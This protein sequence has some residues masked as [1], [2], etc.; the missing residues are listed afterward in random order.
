MKN[1]RSVGQITHLARQLYPHNKGMLEE[2]YQDCMKTPYGYL[3]ID[4]SPGGAD[5]YR[6]RSKIFPGEHPT[7]YIPKQ[8]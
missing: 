8:E 3:V 1:L 7:V 6:L 2:I 5:E 4:L